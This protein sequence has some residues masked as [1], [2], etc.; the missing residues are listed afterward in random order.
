M[1]G[2]LHDLL[3][4]LRM[5][6]IC[7]T[8]LAYARLHIL[9]DLVHTHLLAVCFHGTEGRNPVVESKLTVGDDA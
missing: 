3:S 1:I 6:L 2:C 4:H 7:L 8:S 9:G 5:L